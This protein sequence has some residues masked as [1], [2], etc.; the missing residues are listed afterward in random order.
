VADIDHDEAAD[1]KEDVDADR[2]KICEI[3]NFTDAVAGR[4]DGSNRK[5]VEQNDQ[6]RSGSSQSLNMDQGSTV[7]TARF[8]TKH[9]SGLLSG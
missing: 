1:H 3:V 6:K 7:A 9:R 4:A 2:S 5:S 8:R